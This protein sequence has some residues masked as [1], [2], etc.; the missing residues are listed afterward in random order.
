[1]WIQEQLKT[2]HWHLQILSKKKK[3]T[4]YLTVLPLAPVVVIAEMQF[5]GK[6]FNNPA[7]SK[8]LSIWEPSLVS[9]FVN[10]FFIFMS[11]DAVADSLSL[12]MTF[13]ISSCSSSGPRNQNQKKELWGNV[14]INNQH[15][16]KHETKNNE[17][18]PKWYPTVIVAKGV[19]DTHGAQR[20]VPLHGWGGCR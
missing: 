1:M 8:C 5:F 17:L 14:N 15:S 9:R 2:D 7:V 12:H 11:K 13:S 18:L 3:K 16:D 4:L 19:P 20:L 6:G 10:L